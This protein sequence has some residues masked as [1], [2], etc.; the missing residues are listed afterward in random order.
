[1]KKLIA[2]IM[3]ICIVGGAPPCGLQRCAG[4]CYYGER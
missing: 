2:A 3:S 1:M 4:E